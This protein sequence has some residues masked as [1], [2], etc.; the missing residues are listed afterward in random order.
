MP[1]RSHR[2]PPGPASAFTATVRY[3]RDPLGT[4][5]DTGRR[6]GDPFTWPTFLGPVVV[7]SDPAGIQEILTADPAV[8]G[9]L[10]AELLGPVLG[11]NNLILLSGGPHR[12]MRRF[13]GAHLQGQRLDDYGP[14]IARIASEHAA[15]WPRERPFAVEDTMRAISLDVILEV[16]LGLGDPGPREMFKT[17][18]L[19]LVRA[20]KPSFMFI[21]WLRRP[22]L[23]LSPW[24]RFR[25]RA[26]AAAELFERE[27]V[28]RRAANEPR[29]DLLTLLIAARKADGTA[30]SAGEILEQMVSLI[31][32]GHETTGSGL[33]WALFHVHRNPSVRERLVEELR[34]LGAEAA[35]AAV[36]RL[37]FL[38]AVC[39]EA[40]RLDPVAP[41]IGRTLRAGLTLRGYELPAGQSI[42]ISIAGLH[43]RPDL[44]PEAHRFSPERFLART[45]GPFD[46][47]PFGGGS[48]RC[49][50]ASFAIYEMKLVLATVLR[51][52]RLEL[53]D[54]RDPGSMLRNTT[55]SPA[56][57]IRVVRASPPP[58]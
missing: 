34:G 39:S 13:Y 21:P 18:V 27:V 33:T 12:A 51:A 25:R 22:M 3:L 50:G 9:A 11:A 26:S 17:A 10:G 8:Y 28:T 54:Q 29:R 2:V 1:R 47:L 24:A 56:R 58:R 14:A 36:E 35:P 30:F 57:K 46:Y 31:G 4:L 19:E 5:L 44:Y 38:D 32:A 43:R 40:L 37:P 52:H 53:I 45:H 23:G 49:L 48:R 6:Y 7:T 55:A 20:L 16:V 42:G 41:L 15:A